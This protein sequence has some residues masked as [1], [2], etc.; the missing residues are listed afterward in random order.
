MNRKDKKFDAYIRIK[1]NFD[2]KRNYFPAMLGNDFQ[3]NSL[4]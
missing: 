2:V 1:K 4:L 3:E